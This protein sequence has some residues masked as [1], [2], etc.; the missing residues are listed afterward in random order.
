LCGTAT[1]EV[2]S[3]TYHAVPIPQLITFQRSY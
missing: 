1:F 3:L 2:I